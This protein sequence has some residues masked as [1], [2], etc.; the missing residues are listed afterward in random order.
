MVRNSAEQE[1]HSTIEGQGLSERE[2][3]DQRRRGLGNVLPL[4]T[5]RT[6]TQILR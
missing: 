6:Y 1:L 4:K 2:S 3:A 5:S